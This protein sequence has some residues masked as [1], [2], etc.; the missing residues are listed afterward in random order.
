MAESFVDSDQEVSSTVV[1][2]STML[3]GAI[4]LACRRHPPPLDPGERTN[5]TLLNPNVLVRDNH[6]DVWCSSIG[7]SL[8]CR[9]EADDCTDTL[10]LLRTGDLRSLNERLANF[11]VNVDL[12][13]PKS[14]SDERT[15]EM[16]IDFTRNGHVSLGRL[17][18][19]AHVGA[20][21]TYYQYTR[22]K[23]DMVPEPDL[24]GRS[25]LYNDNVSRFYASRLCDFV[26]SIV[27]RRVKLSYTFVGSYEK[28]ARLPPHVDREQC[29]YTISM[30]ADFIPEPATET[31]WPLYVVQDRV[32]HEIRQ[33]IGDS[34]LFRG[35]VLPHFR[36]RFNS[37]E[38]SISAFFH[39][40]DESF[41]GSLF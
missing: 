6:V 10:N 3:M 25:Y 34:V 26:S 39:F 2:T 5:R 15:S 11:L 28:G 16:H 29:E 31:P 37:G 7:N 41:E 24:E 35:R 21:R 8:P 20:L 32:V 14:L 1:C 4:P 18:P 27:G 9:L 30:Q 23:G 12:V 38:N 22:Q 33:A 13:D 17:F 19:P 40:V 36:K